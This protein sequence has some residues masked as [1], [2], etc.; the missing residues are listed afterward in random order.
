MADMTIPQESVQFELV[1]THNVLSGTFE[2]SGHSK[3]R[4]VS[5]GMLEYAKQL[6][7]RESLKQQILE[8]MKNA[9]RVALPGGFP[10]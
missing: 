4:L 1:I 6:I 8:D 10:S 2:V 7:N 3:N 9:P 5:L